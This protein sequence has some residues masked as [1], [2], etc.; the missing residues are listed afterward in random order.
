[1]MK[2]FYPILT[3]IT[4]VL[5]LA[6]GEFDNAEIRTQIL[7]GPS[8]IAACDTTAP[9]NWIDPVFPKAIVN[10]PWVGWL[11]ATDAYDRPFEWLIA[12]LPNG[13]SLDPNSGTIAGTPKVPGTYAFEAIARLRGCNETM[14]T[15]IYELTVEPE[16]QENCDLP[17]SCSS[18]RTDELFVSIEEVPPG[19]TLARNGLVVQHAALPNLSGQL[20][21]H[22][23]VLSDPESTSKD[24]LII[25]YRL[26]GGIVPTI[27]GE[28]V[29]VRYIHGT[30]GDQYLFITSEKH[31]RLV[32]YNGYL[33]PDELV[34]QCPMSEAGNHCPLV[35]FQL[36]PTPCAR[37]TPCSVNEILA[38]TVSTVQFGAT[39]TSLVKTP[40][41]PGQ[42]RQLPDMTL[43]RVADAVAMQ[44]TADCDNQAF[45]PYNL[46]F[47]VI[48]VAFCSYVEI[49][50]IGNTVSTPPSGIA[51]TS[52]VLY[53]PDYKRVDYQWSREMPSAV[54]QAPLHIYPDG[55][56]WSELPLAGDYRFY[57]TADITLPGGQVMKACDALPAE[58]T[59]QIEPPKGLRVELIWS[60]FDGGAIDPLAVPILS[61]NNELKGVAQAPAVQAIEL[62]LLTEDATIAVRVPP[63]GQQNLNMEIRVW[64]AGTLIAVASQTI[65]PHTD[66]LVGTVKSNGVWS[67]AIP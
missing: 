54:A 20:S 21:S 22:L 29:D 27:E 26:P 38:M 64:Y 36:T 65:G 40:L 56:Y 5:S 44:H 53:P 52:R 37:S 25:E 60:P 67:A 61:I 30:H 12:G 50:P 8:T 10:R 39:S 24:Q 7:N 9:M 14:D 45:I 47:Y 17:E 31:A 42:A 66:W 46:S 32:I 57:L 55:S 43:L 3:W 2:A 4:L 13:L 18:V 41:L 34:V 15:R 33:T 11:H 35:D 48:P 63:E 6:C 62:P 19:G 59:V 23:M 16:C 28:T 49:N 51:L 58:L 1:M